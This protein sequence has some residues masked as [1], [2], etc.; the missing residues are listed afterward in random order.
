M[1]CLSGYHNPIRKQIKFI[2]EAMQ[3]DDRQFIILTSEYPPEVYGGIAYWATNLLST[4]T[5]NGFNAIVLTHKK[6]KHSKLKVISTDKVRY[7]KGHDWHKFNWLYRMPHLLRLLITRKN[8]ILIAGTWNELQVIHRL[9]PFFDLHIYCSSHGTDITKHVFPRKEKVLKKID[10]IFGSVDIFMPVS[11]SLDRL[12]RSMY[13]S[14]SCKSVILGC[15]VNA[16]VF[17]PELD[18]EKKKERKQQLGI[19]STSPLIISVGRMM[20]VKGFRNI[21]MALPYILKRIPDVHYMIVAHPQ[22]PEKQ[23]I[24]HLVKQLNLESHV[25]IRNPVNNNKLPKLLQTADVFALTSEPVYLPYYQEE[26]LPR[27]IPEA[28]ACG[29]PVVVSNTGGLSEAVVDNETG[30]VIRHGDQETLK[31]KLVA[32]LIDKKRAVEMGRKGR[33]HVIKNFSE[34]SMAEKI[35]SIANAEP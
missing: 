28:S 10:H 17:K 4:L 12:A 7:I 11:R 22:E 16:D 13:P 30:F 14:L 6:R 9:K 26:G 32:L 29:L 31:S 15:N 21:I 24:A 27:V 1:Q 3:K 23:L 19:D 20:A 35:L 18:T 2:R 8:V 33:E 34:H 5:R 25:I